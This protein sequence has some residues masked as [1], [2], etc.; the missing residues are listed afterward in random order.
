MEII[1]NKEIR[2]II[3]QEVKKELGNQG[4]LRFIRDH[5]KVEVANFFKRNENK[6]K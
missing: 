4:I 2:E 5:I 3:S 1:N 6:W